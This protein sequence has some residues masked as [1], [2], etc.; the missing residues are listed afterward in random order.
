M[1]LQLHAWQALHLELLLLNIKLRQKWRKAKLHCC[2][3]R[4]VHTPSM[5]FHTHFHLSVCLYVPVS[6]G[7]A[8]ET[9]WIMALQHVQTSP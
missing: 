3:A 1:Q 5:S 7:I 4:P 8:G 2:A 9:P 6:A